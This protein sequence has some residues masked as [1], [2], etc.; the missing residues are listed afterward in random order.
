MTT[1][2]SLA[3]FLLFLAGFVVSWIYQTPPSLGDDINYWGLAFDLHHGVPGA[4]SAGSF[5]DLRWPVWGVC[6]LLQI[7]FGFSAL[8]YYLEPMIYLG[9][10]AALVWALAR[11]V[12]ATERTAI[13]A[14]VLFLFHP[15]IDTIVDR[16]MP[17][18]SEG[19]WVAVAF[20]AWL[21]MV[22]HRRTT[23]KILCAAMVGLALAIGQANRITGVFAI[24]VLLLATVAL[25]P[26][27]I[28]WLAL[29]GLF[30]ASFVGIETV[31]YHSITGDWLH[32]L[33]ANLT[34][35][36][37]PGTETIP[38]WQF[39]FRFL[40]ALFRGPLDVLYNIFAVLGI[41]LVWRNGG[42]PGRALAIYT[43]GYLLTYSCALQSFSPPRPLVRD[44]DRFLGSLAFPLA[45]LSA[46]ALTSVLAFLRAR[47]RLPA[48]RRPN[49]EFL[50]ALGLLVAGIMLL[51]TREKRGPNYL[52]DIAAYLHGVPPGT[53][54]LSHET[55][56]HVA[57]MADPAAAAR[58]DW[59]F[60]K[61]LLDPSPTTL[62]LAD[63]ADE[64][65]FNR[66][67]I[68]TG[69][70]KKSE[71][72]ELESIGTIAPWLRP[73]LAGW[74]ARRAIPKGDVPDF[75]FLRRTANA[76]PLTETAPDGAPLRT[77]LLPDFPVPHT[78]TFATP[79]K[80]DPVELPPHP[81]PSWIANR[82]LFLSTRASSNT[83]EPVRIGVIFL[84]RGIIVQQ[85]AF[86]AYF[87]EKSSEDFFFVTV[88]PGADAVQLRLRLSRKT[89][90]ITLDSFRL[91]VDETSPVPS[92]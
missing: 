14:G 58:I 35:R 1:R 24:P 54:V 91:F 67:W 59:K 37:R 10:G 76:T 36:G 5:H 32:S 83:T 55:M 16:P 28:L 80:G 2:P 48:A 4:W 11:E 87:F 89:K 46:T 45:V 74:S 60:Q 8:S 40:P 52:H 50:A 85:L 69:T 15:Q 64:I 18:L 3:P 72:D 78:W 20:L 44:G 13:V 71:T 39:P 92:S 21:K 73:P 34:A 66:K 90:R 12:G 19:F 41:G 6:W 82:T 22:R 68:W 62:Y 29:G 26:R 88:P 23:T 84:R 30:A 53:H 63:H 81:L 86:K 70:R 57:Y 65:W 49:I 7:P 79:P 38:V 42:P 51:S 25:H 75:V 31:I 43:V 77:E 47:L 17:D 9:A 56:R 61:D 33:H 27:Q